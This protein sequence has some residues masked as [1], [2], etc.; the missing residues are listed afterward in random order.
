MR[1][2]DFETLESYHTETT[3][4]HLASLVLG[5][6]RRLYPYTNRRGDE[7]GQDYNLPNGQ[8]RAMILF[9]N[10]TDT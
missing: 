2:T 5:W 3:Q 6:E 1:T 4:L 9:V 8:R 10:L 7:G